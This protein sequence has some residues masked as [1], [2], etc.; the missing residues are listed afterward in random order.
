MAR[1]PR[2]S[3]TDLPHLVLWRGNNGQ[4]VFIDDADREGFLTL[5]A[6]Q[7]AREG[8][9]VH[10]YA[11]LDAAVWLLLAP[12]REGALSRL[13]Q[14]LGRGY[15]R[16]FNLRHGRTGTLWEGRYRATVLAP[17]RVLAAMVCLDQEPV[18]CGLAPTPEA[19]RWTSHGH[20]A[21]LTTHR[22]LHAPTAWWAL[23]DTPFAREAAYRARVQEGLS[24]DEAQRIRQ[25]AIGGWP[26]GDAA[27][28]QQLQA[29]TGRRMV[30]SRPGRPRKNSNLSPNNSVSRSE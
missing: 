5:L 6:E 7:A 24:V 12:R 19:Y 23:G 14:G 25:A 30:P 13:M 9:D 27:F 11:L 21:G 29:Q 26:L 8:V 17:D 3:V 22:G 1:Q 16:G 4:A 18:R 10:A 15:V 2:V 20:H 28:L